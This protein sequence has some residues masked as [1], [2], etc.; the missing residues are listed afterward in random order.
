MYN[1]IRV[2]KLY[3]AQKAM[4]YIHWNISQLYSSILTLVLR[5]VLLITH[6]YWDITNIYRMVQLHME[7]CFIKL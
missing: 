2:A 6:S 4:Q 5:L 3:V 1:I 7:L